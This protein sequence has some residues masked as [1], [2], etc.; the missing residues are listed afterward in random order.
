MKA[1]VIDA[2]M[3]AIRNPTKVHCVC[4]HSLATDKSE[5]FTIWSWDQLKFL[6]SSHDTLI[7]HNISKYDIPYIERLLDIDLSHMCIIDTLVLSQ[8]Y[9]YNIDG[10]H[11]LRAWGHRLNL[12]KGDFAGPWDVRTKEMMDYCAQDVQ[13]TKA[14]YEFLVERLPLDTWLPVFELEAFI[15]R[16]TFDMNQVG[17]FYDKEMADQYAVALDIQ[18]E[19]IDKLIEQAFPPRVIT[20]RIGKHGRPLKDQ[21]VLFNPSST[22]DV[23]DALWN[24]GWKPFEKTKGHLEYLKGRHVI[25]EKKQR[26]DRYGWKINEENLTT[27]P[28]TAPEGIKLIVKRMILVSRVRKLVE[29][30]KSYDPDTKAVHGNFDGIGTWSHR[31]AHSKPN[32]GN[33]SAKKTIKYKTEELNKLAT[34]WGGKFRSLW[35]A[36]PGKVLV[37]TDAEGIQLR[38]LAHYMN[39]PDFTFAVTSGKKE[40]GTDPHTM[41]MKRLGHVCKTRDIAKTF[42]YA[43]LLNAG[44]R[45]IGEILGVSPGE[46][47]R[48]KEAFTNSY[49]GLAHLK[50]EVIPRDAGRGYF[51]GLDGRLVRC[52][53]E[54]LMMAGYLQNGESIIMKTA[55]KIACEDI[56]LSDLPAE[57]INVV[58][59]EMIFETTPKYA[60]E[61]KRLTER[62]IMYAGQVL[63]LNCPM[64]GEGKIGRNWLE[65]H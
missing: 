57:L 44:N 11:S 59:D 36:R 20:N 52:D 26:F 3:N 30:S 31:M 39:D 18:V 34:D 64:K 40:D 45:K 12:H 63:N 19:K 56:R 9:D 43:F 62:A 55:V 24:A 35:Q 2:E 5:T 16:K 38:V 8:L 1:L 50:G 37:G 54:H 49:P 25:T 6:L 13:V 14:L 61:V 47:G 33:V 51:L 42:I 10:G 60:E 53:S 21:I 65:T 17:F 48:I 58:H 32:L 22:K 41:N 46:G 15:A 4:T 23:I 7:G 27:L 29:W 28:D